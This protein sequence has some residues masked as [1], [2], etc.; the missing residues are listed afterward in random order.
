MSVT[1]EHKATVLPPSRIK[2]V[3][4]GVLSGEEIRKM[5][6]VHVTESTM[7]YRGIPQTNGIND[8]RMGTCDRRLVCGTCGHNVSDCQGHSGHMEIPIPLYQAGFMDLTV[9]ILRSVC[10]GCSRICLAKEEE[11]VEDGIEQGV[12]DVVL[13]G[14]EKNP[15]K[16][17][18][19]SV[20]AQCRTKRRCPHCDMPLPQNYVRSGPN[21]RCDWGPDP[22]FSCEEEREYCTRPFQ[23]TDAFSILRN[24]PKEDLARMGLSSLNPEHLMS[25]CL[26]VPPPVVRPAI[27]VS[28]GSRS[29]GQDDLTI[30]LC[31]IQKK[32]SDLSAFDLKRR[33]SAET[34]ERVGRLQ[35]ECLTMVTNSVRGHKPNARSGPVIKSLIERIKGKDGR[36]RGNLMGKRVNF[37]ARSVITPDVCMDIH[38]VGVP[39]RIATLLTVPERVTSTNIHRLSKRVRVGCGH[40]GGAERV[41]CGDGSILHLDKGNKVRIQP[42]W[43][44]ERY[45][46]EDDYVI[47]NRQPSLHKM[48]IMGHKVKLM[49]G[50][51]FRLNLSCAGPYNADF[52][53]DEMNLHVPQSQAA[54]AEVKH[55]MMVHHQLITP[56]SNK[57]CMGIVQD[58]LLGSYLL[59][60]PSTLLTKRDACFLLSNLRHS[61]GKDG[62]RSL[63]SPSFVAKGVPYW[64]G[65][66]LF[67]LLLPSSLT[68]G[69]P[70]SS[71]LPSSTGT[72]SVLVSHFLSPSL[73]VKDGSFLLGRLSKSNMGTSSGGFVDLLCREHTNEVA[74]NFMSDVQRMMQ[75]YLQT[76]G[77]SVSIRDCV[78]SEE[79]Q[80]QV[81]R[82]LCAANDTSKEIEDHLLSEDT[83]PEQRG[84][85]E[86]TTL[87]ILSRSLGQAATVVD[88]DVDVS[89][90][91]VSMVRCGSKGS[92]INIAQISACVGQQS[93]EG[94]RIGDG[95]G[96]NLSCFEKGD[97]SLRARG[98]VF[99]SY[100]LGLTAF[101]HYFH[102]M[103]GR[104]GLVDTAVK[105]AAT[106][107][108]QRRQVKSM[109]DLTVSY[110]TCVTTCDQVVQFSYGGDGFD[111]SK[112]QRVDLKSLRHPVSSLLLTEEERV[113]FL[114]A[115]RR[116]LDCKC[117][118]LLNGEAEVDVK[119][120][121]P[122]HPQRKR[123]VLMQDGGSNKPKK[124][125]SSSVS[126]NTTTSP[127][128]SSFLSRW[129][130]H[131][132]VI[133]AFLECSST[134][135][136]SLSSKSDAE[137]KEWVDSLSLLC[138]RAKV[139]RGE[140][141]G[142]IAAQ[143]IGEPTTQLT[144]NT[145]HS[146]GIASK[147][148][149]LGIPRL[150]ELLD[151]CKSPKTPLTTLRFKPPFSHIEE[152]ARGV[153]TTLPLMRLDDIVLSCSVEPWRREG[154]RTL[155][156]SS[157]FVEETFLFEEA[158]GLS[159]PQ[160]SS[161][162]GPNYCIRLLLNT[163]VLKLRGMTP[164][165]VR[166]LLRQ[167]LDPSVAHVICSETNSFQHV[168]Q[169]WIL[170]GAEM[171]RHAGLP[172]EREFNLCHRVMVS[173]M[174][175][176]SVGGNPNVSSSDARTESFSRFDEETVSSEK[177]WVV[178]A[179]GNVFQSVSFIPCVDWYRC[180]C[181]D[182]QE[183]Y[184]VLG[185]EAAVS[186]LWEQI[187][188]IISFDGTYV[189]TRHIS[190]IVDT[191]CRNG[192]LMPMSRHGINRLDTGVLT[193]CSFEETQDIL[194]DAASFG[195]EENGKGISMHIM[196]GQVSGSGTGV[197]EMKM[198]ES[199]INPMQR[200]QTHLRKM[201]TV[202]K[203]K[204]K[205]PLSDPEPVEWEEVKKEDSL[206]RKRNAYVLRSPSPPPSSASS[207]RLPGKS[208]RKRR[209]K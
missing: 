110:G 142:T 44:V 22:D 174:E 123:R 45:L 179:M 98:M 172:Q 38:Q 36:V 2:S 193:R 203:S 146:A 74:A 16:N 183:V 50:L 67:S 164:L 65:K 54:T 167:R 90:A 49:K 162:H 14:K 88:K 37:S 47:F 30:K 205:V 176:V 116:I 27:S 100:A 10:F 189:D 155:P 11:G 96:R 202:L 53:G 46:Q 201:P 127:H 141:V 93:V 43:V 23:Q 184:S 6:V 115:R 19:L 75:V 83:T 80:A 12:E 149:T 199:C 154:G 133:V 153:S 40:I 117:H 170:D 59:S 99:N 145:F 56:Q 151:Q 107:Y 87:R 101:E 168:V 105:T 160:L 186:V 159:P 109:E 106:G 28:D 3:H 158:M 171:M 139:D 79:G 64:T 132:S 131:P 31:D 208:D 20:F 114:E 52:D 71:S 178:D 191:M 143:S 165:T 92:T 24:I 86:K 166:N 84:V 126:G 148:V 192:Y 8:H 48:S 63:P 118:V 9:K 62:K 81:V 113:F 181:N 85:A 204:V 200:A 125:L 78:L 7:Y 4:F 15:S 112:L 198:H 66:A 195:E 102:T 121:V 119:I 18:F 13:S 177:E 144:L 156:S 111:A 180:T 5:S 95:E 41:I 122:F 55:L 34:M 89:N 194:F 185:I 173:L 150:K 163:S 58:A 61:F 129:R 72:E 209:K 147:N 57:P 29:R 97:T 188:R 182:V 207:S 94:A 169:V 25:T 190:L 60:S 135:L 26:L 17:L 136:L 51:T 175:T 161:P 124:N 196:T 120:P 21:I 140:M 39:E 108:I 157:S 1:V 32:I 152:V 134:H 77:F 104:E 187:T 73:H 128:V 42:G 68:V 69:A 130:S 137:A 197:T 82:E 76:V 91:I 35:I 206:P 33:W 70:P 138:E 103:G